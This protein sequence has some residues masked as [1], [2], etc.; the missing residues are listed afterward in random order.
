MESGGEVVCEWEG[1]R[2]GEVVMSEGVRE[3]ELGVRGVHGGGVTCE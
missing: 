1:G 2:G 3:W